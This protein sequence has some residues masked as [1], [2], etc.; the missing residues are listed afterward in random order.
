MGDLPSPKK[1]DNLDHGTC[2]FCGRTSG[3]VRASYGSVVFNLLTTVE[4]AQKN[5]SKPGCWAYPDMLEVLMDSGFGN[6]Y[7]TRLQGG[8]IFTEL[9]VYSIDQLYI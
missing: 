2:G 8:N 4:W 5:L 9:A 3:D 7:G 1:R 6:F